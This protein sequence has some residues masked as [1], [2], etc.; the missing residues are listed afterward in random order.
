MKLD[1]LFFAA[2]PDD[3]E[4]CAGGTI[5]K[6]SK[7][8]KKTGIIDLT[9]GEL[10]TRG[11]VIER[12]SESEN[13]SKIL[14]LSARENLSIQDGNIENTP[15]NRL[16]VISAIRK[17]RPEIIFFPHYH[18]RHPDHYHTHHLIKDAAFYSG[19]AK[20]VTPGLKPHRPKRNFYYMQTYTFEPNIII[21][22]SDTFTHKMKAVAC[23]STQFYNPDSKGPKTFISDKKFI[24]Y[25]T[26]RLKFYGFQIGA[27]YGEPFYTEEKIKLDVKKLFD[28]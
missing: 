14:G 4:L 9:R 10:G 12:A 2:H 16:K 7:A 28:I 13:A 15:E 23:Y 26:A 8:G 24:E 25:I 17:Y 20:I 11:S 19:L 1:A 22:I 3:A 5:K 27:E 6:L 21:D 18:D